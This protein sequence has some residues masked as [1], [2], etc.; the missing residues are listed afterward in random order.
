MQQP[1]GKTQSYNFNLASALGTET[2]VDNLLN[3]SEIFALPSMEISG[4]SA[5]NISGDP[6][7]SQDASS[8]LNSQ[9]PK[10]I[11]SLRAKISSLVIDTNTSY[12]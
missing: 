5:N 10:V 1:Q 3:S 7:F 9:D 8:L 12:V 4:E 6:T 11:Q 2:M